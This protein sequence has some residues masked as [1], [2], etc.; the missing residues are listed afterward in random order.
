MKTFN[1]TALLGMDKGRLVKMIVELQEW[2]NVLSDRNETYS[3]KLNTIRAIA[4]ADIR[5]KG[6][7]GLEV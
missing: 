4:D 6:G 5:T 3:L 2:V 1:E 7:D